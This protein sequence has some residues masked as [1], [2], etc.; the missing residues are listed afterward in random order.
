M[1]PSFLKPDLLPHYMDN[2][3]YETKQ[4]LLKVVVNVDFV[5][6]NVNVEDSKEGLKKLYI[7]FL[8]KKRT[9]T[10][11]ITRIFIHFDKK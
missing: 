3:K 6:P 2:S 5:L 9:K 8:A 11:E 1:Y 10:L 4:S 7:Y